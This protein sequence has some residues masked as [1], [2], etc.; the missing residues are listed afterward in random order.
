MPK[1]ELDMDYNYDEPDKVEGPRAFGRYL[2]LDAIYQTT[3]AKVY[4]ARTIDKDISK[5]LA[6]KIFSVEASRR[7]E[8]RQIYLSQLKNTFHLSHPGVV[9]ISDYGMIDQQLF[10]A[11]EYI[12]GRN[13][14]QIIEQLSQDKKVLPI[15]VSLFIASKLCETLFYAHTFQNKFTGNMSPIIHQRVSSGN[16]MLSNDGYV[17]LMNF[18]MATGEMDDFVDVTSIQQEELQKIESQEKNYVS[19]LAPEYLGKEEIDPRFD[20]FS[21][22]V[23]IWELITGNKL[24]PGNTTQEILAKII[25]SDVPLPSQFNAEAH[26]EL[27]QIIMKGLSTRRELRYDSIQTMNQHLIRYLQKNYPSFN[28]SDLRG[29]NFAIFKT[30]IRQDRALMIRL[31]QIDVSSYMEKSKAQ[32]E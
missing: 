7:Q 23:I 31:G 18:G 1:L 14:Q 11:M 5:F 20:Q 8:Y 4:R 27:D 29:V 22:A 26:L 3:G 13:L 30:Q 32:Q 21:V 16:V 24:F 12:D 9:T 17:K 28:P 15:P 10:V 19:Y 2:L 6:V 25:Q